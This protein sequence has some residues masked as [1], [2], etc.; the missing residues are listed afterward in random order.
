[1]RGLSVLD[2]ACTCSCHA[3]VTDQRPRDYHQ[4]LRLLTTDE[5]DRTTVF[6]RQSTPSTS[7]DLGEL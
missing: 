5:K 3:E 2:P 4:L 7:F 6:E 1:M